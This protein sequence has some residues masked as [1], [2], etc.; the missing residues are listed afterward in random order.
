MMPPSQLI[1]LA[2]VLFALSVF[3]PPVLCVVLVKTTELLGG[4]GI[5]ETIVPP[6]ISPS[7]SLR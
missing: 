2:G 5:E 1:V 7:N 6:R 4:I 3:V